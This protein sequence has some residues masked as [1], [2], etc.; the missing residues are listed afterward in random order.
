MYLIKM[1]FCTIYK[2]QPRNTFSK[3]YRNRFRFIYAGSEHK[4]I[5]ITTFSNLSSPSTFILSSLVLFFFFSISNSF[6]LQHHQSCTNLQ[7]LYDQSNLFSL[8][9]V[10]VFLTRLLSPALPP[11]DLLNCMASEKIA[12]YNSNSYKR[13][14]KNLF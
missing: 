7:Q 2:I 4:R 5:F 3:F 12:S 10:N 8:Q 13:L 6:L 9:I 14:H 1:L 11:K